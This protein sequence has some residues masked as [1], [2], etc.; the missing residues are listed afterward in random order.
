MKH[1]VRDN[2]GKND[3]K[4]KVPTNAMQHHK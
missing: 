2:L 3:E 4:N 1:D